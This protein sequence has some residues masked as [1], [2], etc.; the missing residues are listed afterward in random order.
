M[1]FIKTVGII[2]ILFALFGLL[3]SDSQHSEAQRQIK[4]ME[5]NNQIGLA[6]Y[7]SS[8][9]DMMES[10]ANNLYFMS[11]LTS[12]ITGAIGYGFILI[13]KKFKAIQVD[14]DVSSTK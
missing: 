5:L 7:D 14:N 11:I 9:I 4:I 10:E 6:N 1:S 13:D 2:L 12:L 8:W 3:M